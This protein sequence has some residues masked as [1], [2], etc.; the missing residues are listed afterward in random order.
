[1]I[2]SPVLY[3]FSG[4][5]GVGK[6]TLAKQLACEYGCTY[7]RIDTIEQAL[8]D[9]CNY[10]VQGEGYRLSYRIATENLKNGM[11]VVADSCNPISITRQEWSQVAKDLSVSYL[12]IFITCSDKVEH[13]KRV[14]TRTVLI[15]NLI[16]P[17]W[18][19]VIN[20]EFETWT[21]AH[22]VLDTA[23]KTPLESF[24]ELLSLVEKWN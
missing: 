7:L 21:D 23:A 17:S 4:L 16:L 22:I 9:L 19:D 14:E 15:P 1:M 6:S 18:Q 20:R 8:R 11:S 13:K 12:N 24:H 5:P 2:K 10:D 3:I